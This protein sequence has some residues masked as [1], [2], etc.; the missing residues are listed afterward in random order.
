VR[1]TIEL[2]YREER[3]NTTYSL[4]D[5]VLEFDE[6]TDETSEKP[7]SLRHDE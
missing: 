6:L 4:V 3:G 7:E 1:V 5:G 2:E